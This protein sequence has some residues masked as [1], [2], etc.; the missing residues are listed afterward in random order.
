[1]PTNSMNVSIF[2][3]R[4]RSIYRL[5]VILLDVRPQVWRR[6]QL[7]GAT[8]LD[9]LHLILQQ[10]LGWNDCHEHQFVMEDKR[11]GEIDPDLDD[12]T[13][14][15]STVL[16]CDILLEPKDELIYE[17]D[18]GDGWEHRVMLETTLPIEGA[19]LVPV[20]LAGARACPPEDVGGPPGYRRMLR[21]LANPQHSEYRDYCNFIDA[22]FDAEEFDIEDVNDRL[23]IYFG[24]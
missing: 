13:V 7:P 23:L 19:S 18:F 20:C 6:I 11:F 14:D 15:E 10:V 3:R 16:L 8:S 4:K 1:L 12:D 5:K 24:A 2:P 21:V 22:D 17:Y 9:K